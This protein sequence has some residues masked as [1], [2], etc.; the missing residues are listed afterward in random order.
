M[1]RRQAL[2]VTASLAGC[3]SRQS[4]GRVRLAISGSAAVLEY[5]PHALAQQLGLYRE[6]SLS[7]QVESVLAAP[8]A[9][10][11]GSADVVVGFF[12]HPVR[13]T[14]LGPAVTAFVVLARYPGE[15]IVTSARASKPIRHL[16]DLKGALV[17]IANR[18]G[19]VDFFTKYLFIR[20]GL[21]PGDVPGAR[22]IDPKRV[23]ST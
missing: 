10:M 8:K 12:D 3:R 16:A 14:A 5:L 2:A 15:A 9:L 1:T 19:T 11:G 7:L 18:G 22:R 17:G 20:H 21:S 23:S 4:T 6:Q 13:I